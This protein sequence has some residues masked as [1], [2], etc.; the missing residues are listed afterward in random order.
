MS[1]QETGGYTE[2]FQTSS[3][4]PPLSV[5]AVRSDE[6]GGCGLSAFYLKRGGFRSML[7]VSSAMVRYLLLVLLSLSCGPFFLCKYSARALLWRK[8]VIQLIQ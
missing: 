4:E 8:A 2:F 5:V 3:A 1:L 6:L 7:A